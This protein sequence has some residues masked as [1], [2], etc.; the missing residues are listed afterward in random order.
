MSL[1]TLEEF[2][3]EFSQLYPEMVDCYDFD[4]LITL[5]PED[6]YGDTCTD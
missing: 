4:N 5:I 3:S 2:E 1:I 6:I